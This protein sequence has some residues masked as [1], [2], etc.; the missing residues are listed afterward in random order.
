MENA[1]FGISVRLNW[2]QSW[3][4]AFIGT[5]VP[6]TNCALAQITPDGT[7]PNNSIININGNTLNIT[8]GT[9]AGDN[10]FHSFKDFSVSTGSEAFFNNTVD[11]QNIISRVTGGSVSNIDGSIRTLGT[12]NLLLINPNG[13]VFGPNAQ[14]NVDGSFLASTASNLKFADGFEFRTDGTQT[15]PLLTISV[16]RGLQ[17]GANPGKIQVIGD[18]QGTRLTTDLIDTANALRLGA[19]QTLALV[20]GDLELLGGTLKSTGGRIELGSVGSE[21]LVGLVSV[22]NGW[23]LDYGGVQNFRDIQLLQQATVDASGIGGGNVRVQGRQITLKQGSRIEASTL[24]FQSGGTLEVTGIESIQLDGSGGTYLTMLAAQVYKGANGNGGNI[25][26]TT[27]SVSLTNGVQL[28]AST[29]GKGDAG[30]VL[31]QAKDSVSVA[32]NSYIFSTVESQGVGKGGDVNISAATLSLKDG[33]Q[34]GTFVREASSNQTAGQGQAGNVNVN[35]TGEV[36][37][38]GRKNGASGIFSTL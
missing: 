15:T 32:G 16:P 3:G 37:I 20:G 38:T 35:V 27:G 18:G 30:S 25:I 36:T 12:T 24:G 14:L 29:F 6:F 10:L 21:S 11:I 7:L 9:Q 5:F 17:F 4:I 22:A 8:G 26:L 2:F 19:N 31:V 13:I 28:S 34:L 1:M 33:A 23:T